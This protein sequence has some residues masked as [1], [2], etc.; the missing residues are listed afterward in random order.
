[1]SSEER[2]KR[3]EGERGG[4]VGNGGKGVGDEGKTGAVVRHTELCFLPI[5]AE[6]EA[7]GHSVG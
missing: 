4:K 2:A 5:S 7:F 3:Q 6:Q 1:M